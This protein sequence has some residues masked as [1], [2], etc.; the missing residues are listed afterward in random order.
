MVGWLVGILPR[1]IAAGMRT[2]AIAET[3]DDVDAGAG[4]GDW[5]GRGITAAEVHGQDEGK[6]PLEPI[7]PTHKAGERQRQ[8]AGRRGET[9]VDRTRVPLGHSGGGHH[10]G[11]RAVAALM[12]E[13]VPQGRGLVR[14]GAVQHAAQLLERQRHRRILI[15]DVVVIIA[16]FV[17]ILV[18]IQRSTGSPPRPAAAAS[19]PRPS[20]PLRRAATPPRRWSSSAPIPASG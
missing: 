4:P 5:G 8:A 7:D 3:V 1:V 19:P 11:S 18:P 13:R 12:S 16:V 17:A 14:H 20:S 10:R 15:V 6:V 9:Q 2:I